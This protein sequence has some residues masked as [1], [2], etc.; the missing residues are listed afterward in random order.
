MLRRR[1]PALRHPLPAGLVA[2]ERGIAL[3]IRALEEQ[4]HKVLRVINVLQQLM[5]RRVGDRTGG[6]GNGGGMHWQRLLIPSSLSF[7]GSG[8]TRVW[9][10]D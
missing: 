7:A 2:E 10:A 1:T 6:V 8:A 9:C 3:F 5:V 4:F